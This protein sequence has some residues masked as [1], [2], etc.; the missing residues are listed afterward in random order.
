[1]EINIWTKPETLASHSH[2]EITALVAALQKELALK[3]QVYET[4]QNALADE[5]RKQVYLFCQIRHL[6]RAIGAAAPSLKWEDLIS[7]K[8]ALN[9]IARDYLAFLDLAAPLP[10]IPLPKGREK[11]GF[12][13]A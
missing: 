11:G 8:S 6:E 9:F 4:E 2:E 3:N 12:F 7:S 13:D 10:E 5:Y 1:M